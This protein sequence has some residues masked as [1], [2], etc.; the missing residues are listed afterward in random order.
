MNSY[1]RQCALYWTTSVTAA[2]SEDTNKVT[3]TVRCQILDDAPHPYDDSCTLSS[4]KLLAG[5]YVND[6]EYSDNEHEL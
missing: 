3:L 6:D 2:H 5:F 1:G 4:H